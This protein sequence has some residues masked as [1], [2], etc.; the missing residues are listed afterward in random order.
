ML[1]ER[2][3]RQLYRL[4]LLTDVRHV[5]LQ[6]RFERL[7]EAFYERLWRDAA[8]AIGARCGPTR[9]GLLRIERG[10]FA[11]FVRQSEVMLDD[12]MTLEVIGNK[13]LTYQLLAENGVN[14][15]RHT[16]YTMRDL[17]PAEILM[18]Q[19]R[20]PVVVKP[21]GGTGGGRGVTTGITT[22]RELRK[23]SRRASRFDRHLLIEPQQQGHN[24]RLLYLNGRLIDAIRRD[25][26]VLCGDGSSSIRALVRLANKFRL[27]ADTTT[28]LSP[29]KIDNDSINWLRSEDLTPRSRP[30]KGELVQIKRAINENSAAQNHN[31]LAEVH[32]ATAELSA[33]VIGNL[34]LRFVG[35]DIIC[36]DI[37]APLEAQNG[38]ISE[39]NTQPGIHHHYLVAE[40]EKRV[41]VAELL[42]DEMF[43]A[44]QGVMQVSLPP[45]SRAPLEA[46]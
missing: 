42:L 31:V 1:P 19:T 44:A 7:R 25:P 38:Y 6:M 16:V 17:A 28:A 24:Y 41:P 33:R 34:G 36:R 5:Y 4:R 2:A 21:V 8:A 32:P 18:Q 30:A 37:S 35:L 11:T 14:V 40:P 43:G 12:P 26:P 29:L 9:Y 10:G 27:T 22:T 45:K 46:A 15:A 23:A 3:R 20:G 39:I 13:A